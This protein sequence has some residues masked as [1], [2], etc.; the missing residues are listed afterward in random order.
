VVLVREFC[1]GLTRSG[2][3]SSSTSCVDF[4]FSPWIGRYWVDFSWVHIFG[5]LKYGIWCTIHFYG[6]LKMGKDVVCSQPFVG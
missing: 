2:N 3:F 1:D 4:G 6:M 5:T